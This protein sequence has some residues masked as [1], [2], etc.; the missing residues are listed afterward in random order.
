VVR[1]DEPALVVAGLRPGVGEEHVDRREP[2]RRDPV[3]QQLERVAAGTLD[4]VHAFFPDPW[5]KARHHKRRLFQPAHVA[6]LASR[7]RPG[8]TIRCA[9]DSPGY[10]AAMVE[11]LGADPLLIPGNGRVPRPV[12]KF[13]QRA[14]DAGRAVVDLVY[15]RR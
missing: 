13:E 15:V 10:A 11:T 2:G 8:G 6:L 4:A 3:A 9:T 7:L 12:T 14:R 5:P 1:L